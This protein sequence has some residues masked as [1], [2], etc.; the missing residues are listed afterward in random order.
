MNGGINGWAGLFGTGSIIP[1][2]R[3][4]FDSRFMKIWNLLGSM[5]N[6]S[7][8]GNKGLVASSKYFLPSFVFKSNISAIPDLNGDQ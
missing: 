3:V 4:L 7:S 5:S 2:F 6:S 8:F 1:K